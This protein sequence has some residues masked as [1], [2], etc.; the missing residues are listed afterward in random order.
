MKCI[1]RCETSWRAL[2]CSM[3]LAAG[4]FHAPIVTYMWPSISGFLGCLYRSAPALYN[5]TEYEFYTSRIFS[6][7]MSHRMCL[8]LT[9][10]EANQRDC[11]FMPQRSVS[12]QLPRNPEASRRTL[13][14]L[15]SATCCSLQ[16][17]SEYQNIPPQESKTTRDDRHERLWL[18]YTAQVLEFCW[19]LFV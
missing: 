14:H 5:S 13:I 7:W 11:K 2:M 3:T 19:I 8:F 17:V 1:D 18:L 4:Q 15:C 16:E 10:M 9:T 6:S 12:S